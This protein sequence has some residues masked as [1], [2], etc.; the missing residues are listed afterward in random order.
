MRVAEDPAPG[1]G[2]AMDDCVLGG[3]AGA[4]AGRRETPPRPDRSASSGSSPKMARQHSPPSWLPG[5]GP[6]PLAAAA[7]TARREMLSAM[8]S[9]TAVAYT[10]LDR[11]QPVLEILKSGGCRGPGSDSSSARGELRRALHGEASFGLH[12]QEYAPQPRS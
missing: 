10:V 4:S 5:S 6:L 9:I 11:L 1:Q 2:C 12:G 8:S 7:T 3:L